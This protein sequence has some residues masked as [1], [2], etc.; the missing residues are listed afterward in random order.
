M[1][2]EECEDKGEI[3]EAASVYLVAR[4][5]QGG[6]DE[7]GCE[8]QNIQADIQGTELEENLLVIH[9]VRVHYLVKNPVD[10]CDGQE[11]VEGGGRK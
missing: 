11:G 8:G 4:F 1:G 3:I 5:E 2:V 6:R 10:G 9:I 7:A